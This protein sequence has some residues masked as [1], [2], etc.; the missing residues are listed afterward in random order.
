MFN[1]VAKRIPFGLLVVITISLVFRLLWLDKVPTGITDDELGFIMNSK[2]VFLTGKDISGVW[3]PYA[4]T[5]I[6]GAFPQAEIPYIILAPIIGPLPLSLLTSKIPYVI[7]STLITVLLYLITTKLI[8]KREA[9]FVGLA[10][11]INPWSVFFGRTAYEAPIAIFFYLLAFYVLIRVKGWSILY[12]F[13]PLFIAFYSYMGTKLIF[14][15]YACFIILYAWYGVN[16]KKY[17]RKY[18]LLCAMCLILFVYFFYSIQHQST[19]TRLSELSTPHNPA[20]AEDVNT[21]RR[22]SIKTPVTNLVANKYVAWG[23]DSIDKYLTVFSTDILFLNGEERSTFSLWYH[24]YF[25]YLDFFFIIIG[26]CLLYAVKRPLWFLLSGFI[27]IAPIATVASNVETG[28]AALRASLLFPFFIMLTGLGISH[29]IYTPKHKIYTLLA[30]VVLFI[31]YGIHVV[32]FSTIYFFRNPLYNSE[33]YNLSSRLISRYIK[34]ADAHDRIVMVISDNPGNEFLH[35]LFDNNLYNRNTAATIR[36]LM[37]QKKYEYHNAIFTHCSDDLDLSTNNTII[38][39]V[40][41]QCLSVDFGI[42][43]DNLTISNLSDGGGI[44]R[45]VHDTMCVNYALVTYPYG[46]SLSD[47]AVE[48]VPEQ[49]FCEKFIADIE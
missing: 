16:H 17:T 3:S 44:Y 18:G 13:I 36:E 15:P 8:G 5:P 14:I 24:G 9:F 7:L 29:I 20:Y 2:A 43:K 49:R 12:A 19:K 45:I 34:L 32:N 4:L 48:Q 31:A 23:K 46:F 28:F 40:T 35:Y 38:G 1:V 41:K 10:G 30:C 47:F 26:F 27:L 33:A 11:A 21:E 37:R 6:T 22:L 25:Y 39:K 42:A